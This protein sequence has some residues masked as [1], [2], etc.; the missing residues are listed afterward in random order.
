MK[1]C[2]LYSG[3]AITYED[4]V[5]LS[6]VTSYIGKNKGSVN[7]DAFSNWVRV[8][9]NLSRNTRLDGLD[10]YVRAVQSIADLTD[11]C[12]DLLDYLA[13][14]NCTLG[15]FLNEQIEE[16][17]LK[18][19][20][21]LRDNDWATAI[22]DAE[23]HSYFSGQIAF[24]MSFAGLDLRTVDSLDDVEL[25]RHLI[26]FT[27]YKKKV[28]VLFSDKGLTVN[29]DLFSRAVLSKG[30]YLLLYRRCKSFLIGNHRDISWKTL[31]RNSNADKRTFL[32]AVLDELDEDDLSVKNIENKLNEIIDKTIVDDWRHY[33]V[34]MDG[35][36]KSCGY[37]RL[38]YVSPEGRILLVSCQ[39]TAGYNKEYYTYVVYLKL[40]FQGKKPHYSSDRGQYGEMFIERLDGKE[41]KANYCQD[42]NKHWEFQISYN[43]A[44]YN[45]DT[46]DDVLNCIST[47]V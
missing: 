14:P 7:P 10:D 11:H 24:L 37:Y 1:K 32:K 2:S 45:K 5:M 20:L 6:A 29:A 38:I 31:L 47:L 41:L 35:L 9:E 46:V 27:V 15:G 3:T 13:S 42:Q 44:N 19:K 25:N 36:L 33:F 40:L 18:A 8:L 12:S 34:K 28:S 26:R 16:E 17:R 30:D 39:T 21:I 43:G 4:R 23:K 22:Y